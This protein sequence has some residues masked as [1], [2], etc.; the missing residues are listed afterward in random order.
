MLFG[1]PGTG[2][3]L[4]RHWAWP[5]PRSD[6]TFSDPDRHKIDASD[7]EVS[8]SN[9]VVTLSGRVDSREDKR[10]TEEIAESVRGVKDVTNQLR[11]G[12]SDYTATTGT[13]TGADIPGATRARTART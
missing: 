8:V 11:I 3:E 13:T 6:F 4:F 9:A 5:P 10:R 1:R 2:W 7:I 12:Q